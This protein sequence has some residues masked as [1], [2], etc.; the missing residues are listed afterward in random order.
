[1]TPPPIRLHDLATPELIEQWAQAFDEA[2]GG[3]VEEFA[4]WLVM[5]A[6]G[7]DMERRYVGRQTLGLERR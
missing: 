5:N 2:G 3:T 6:K 4:E 1:M 7:R